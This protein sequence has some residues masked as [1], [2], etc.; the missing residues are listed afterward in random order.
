MRVPPL[1]QW[2]AVARGV[3]WGVRARRCVVHALDAG[4]AETARVPRCG[5]IAEPGLKGVR[6]VLR[7]FRDRC[8]VDAL[9]RQHW[10]RGHGS[11]RTLMIGVRAPAEGFAAHAWL[12]GDPPSSAAG[13]T[14]LARRPAR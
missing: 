2:P 7:I 5:D 13:F 9:V 6:L 14:E 1:A 3:V 12:E 4:N 11:S 8:L 10:H